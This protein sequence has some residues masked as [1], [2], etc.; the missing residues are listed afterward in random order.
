MELRK[1]SPAGIL[2]MTHRLTKKVSGKS[3][4]P[5]YLFIYL[6]REIIL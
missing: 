3:V 2:R 4:L 1:T 6:L 5:I